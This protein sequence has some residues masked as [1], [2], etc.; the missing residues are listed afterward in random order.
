MPE[1]AQNAARKAKI[2]SASCQL[3]N[4]RIAGVPW[5]R[6]SPA[7]SFRARRRGHLNWESPD[8]KRTLVKGVAH[9]LVPDQPKK[10]LTLPVQ[11]VFNHQTGQAITK[12]DG[13]TRSPH[14]TQRVRLRG[15]S[16]HRYQTVD[17]L[18]RTHQY[19]PMRE[20][21]QLQQAINHITRT[22]V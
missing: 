7:D 15:L 19:A 2:P 10:P 16:G 18:K 6:A 4:H 14:S 5:S 3:A 8:S 20:L 12:A 17:P 11:V 21:H 9:R 13:A 22:L 1:A